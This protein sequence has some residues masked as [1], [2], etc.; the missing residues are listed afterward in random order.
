[1]NTKI[2]RKFVHL[3]HSPWQKFYWS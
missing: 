3:F 2:N 1:M